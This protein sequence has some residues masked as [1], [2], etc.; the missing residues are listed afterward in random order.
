VGLI[1]PHAARLVV[2]VDHRR[3]LLV[4]ALGGA[5]FLVL[6]DLAARVAERPNEL[7][8]SVVTSLFGAPFFV[9]LLRRQGRT[10]EEA[11]G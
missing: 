8:L 9:W 5:L 10:R 4:S 3:L 7:P 1:I 11:L 2:G 6:V